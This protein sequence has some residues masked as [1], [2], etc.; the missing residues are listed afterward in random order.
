MKQPWVHT[1]SQ[2]QL[3]EQQRQLH[4]HLNKILHYTIFLQIKHSK[5]ITT[6]DT[7]RYNSFNFQ[8]KISNFHDLSYQFIVY[9]S[10]SIATKVTKCWFKEI[11]HA[12]LLELSYSY[13]NKDH[14]TIASNYW[15]KTKNLKHGS[16]TAH[17][18]VPIEI[19]K[20]YEE[21]YSQ[22]KVDIFF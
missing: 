12:E 17:K 14:I 15:Q 6:L 7:F 3:P 8:F 5:Q 19:L 2:C 21:K 9:C 20:I 4:I 1:P 11:R 18:T 22:L 13:K 10:W 16:K